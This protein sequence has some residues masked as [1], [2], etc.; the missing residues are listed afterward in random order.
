MPSGSKEIDTL[1]PAVRKLFEP[2]D[3]CAFINQAAVQLF[4]RGQAPFGFERYVVEASLLPIRV[5][6][7]PGFEQADVA[8]MIAE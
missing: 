7:G 8:E 2:I 5:G 1:V 3:F 4:E 6:G